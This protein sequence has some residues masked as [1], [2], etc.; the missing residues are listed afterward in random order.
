MTTT[1]PQKIGF[2][3]L[4]IMGAPMAGHLLAAGHQL[5]VHTRSKVPA[6]IAESGATQCTTARGVAERADVVITMLPDTPDVEAVLFG[7]DGVAAGLQHGGRG[8]LVIDMSSISPVE[9]RAF[10]QRIEALGADYLD[11]PVSGGDVGARN[12]TLSIMCGGRPEAFERARPVLAA[13]GRNITRVGASG[14]GQTCKVANQVIVA[15]TIQAVA[16]GL[17]FAARAGADPAA[18]RQA[19]LGGLASSRILEVLGER[20]VARNF[21]PGF[22]IALH[23]KD[24][25]L[26]LSAARRLGLALPATAGAQQL[27]SACVAQGGA[28]WDHSAL[29]RAL[30]RLSSFE[31][32]QPAD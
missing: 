6:A 2:I 31:I 10:A 21:A 3:G 5:Y 25:N 16:E 18:V 14:D 19:L 17:L 29:V 4:G 1:T 28:G 23:Q 30:E 15:L 7:E 13:M 20:M 22:R 12:A 24:L 11:A 27:F 32:G 8:K 9:T 26:A